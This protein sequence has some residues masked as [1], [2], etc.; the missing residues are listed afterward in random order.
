MKSN[1]IAVIGKNGNKVKR[2]YTDDFND[3]YRVADI[4]RK[5]GFTVVFHGKLEA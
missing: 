5:E 2:Y 1:H 4:M 3:A